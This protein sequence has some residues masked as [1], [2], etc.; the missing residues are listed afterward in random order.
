MTDQQ[1]EQIQ[2]PEPTEEWV[3]PEEHLHLAEMLSMAPMDYNPATGHFQIALEADPAAA[4]RTT[5][6]IEATTA[7]G[8]LHANLAALKMQYEDRAEMLSELGPSIDL[9]GAKSL[10]DGLDAEE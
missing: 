7:L 8:H 4:E 6:R 1:T 9:V 3:T 10:I 2:N 5:R